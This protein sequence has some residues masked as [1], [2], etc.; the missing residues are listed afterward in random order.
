MAGSKNKKPISVVADY[1]KPKK[2]KKKKKGKGIL[3]TLFGDRYRKL[4]AGDKKSKKKKKTPF[5]NLIGE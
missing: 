3:D 4:H 1:F 2:K 5:S